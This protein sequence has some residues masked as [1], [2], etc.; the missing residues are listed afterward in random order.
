MYKKLINLSCLVLLLGLA[1]K[2]SAQLLVHYKLDETSGTVAADMSGKGNDG[3]IDGA[4]NWAPGWID[5]ALQF[6]GS[7]S[8]T[9]PA[10]NMGLRS[11]TGSVAF[12]MNMAELMGG[13][14][15]IWW[16]GDNT[17]G[18]GMGPENEMHVHIETAVADVW[19]GGE[20][21]FRV[22]HGPLVHLHS[23]PE[24]GDA[25]VP[26]NPPVN[27]V[28]VNDGQWHHVVCTWGDADGNVNLYLDGSLLQQAAYTTPSYPL[29][30]IYLG[31]M[32]DGGR[33]YT[34][35][36]DDVQIY[37]GALTEDEIQMVMAGSEVLSLPAALPEPANQATDVPLDTVLS[38][39]AGDR[40]DKHNV[41]FGTSLED[42]ENADTTNPR[43]V[44][45]AEN[46]DAS[47]YAP[48]ELLEFDQTYYWRVDEVNAP[49]EAGIIK[50]DIWSFT[51]VNFVVVDDFE[52]YTDSSPDIV[53]ET[54]LD[55][56]EIEE[57]GSN[58]GY[59]DPPTMEQDI[60]HG[61]SKSMPFFYDNNMRYSQAE[62]S[63]TGSTT[64]WTAND[65]V[66]VSLWFRGNRRY[67]GSFVEEPAGTFTLTGSGADI[68]AAADEFHFAFKEVTGAS[69]I[70]AKVESLDNTDPFAKAGV[71]IRDTL[72]ADS[73]YAGVFIT[74]ENGVRFQ[75]RN[76]VAATT[77]RSFAEGITAPQWVKLERTTG[78]LIRSYYSADG[79]TWTRFNLIQVAMEMPVYVGLAVTSHNAELA[80]QAA[81]SNV[82][83]PN[84]TVAAEWTDQ[85]VGMLSNH[86]EPMYLALNGKAVYHDDP[87]AVLIDTWTQ[88]T[89]PLQAFATQG[90]DLTNVETLA[91]GFGDK[92]N[93]RP[94]G[95][96]TVYFDDIRLYR[97]QAVEGPVSVPIE[98]SSFE[99][100]GTD[101]QT[102][103]DNVAGWSTDGPCADSGVETGYTPTDGD[104]TAYLMSGDPSVWQLTDHI[105]AEGQTIEL[106]ID[107]R[108][109][110]AATSMLMVIYYDDN[111]TRVPV[112]TIDVVLSD[113]M[114]EFNLSFSAGDVPESVGRNVGI[115]FS[116]S[117]SGDTWVGLD[118][119]RLE[120]SAK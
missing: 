27:P 65:V 37:G 86:A 5:G 46:Q 74:P 54:W 58:I 59:A 102:G 82:S 61:G 70:I 22:L 120:A 94:G 32:A 11:D 92:D 4:A 10:G 3:V 100:P 30:N 98:N 1:G 57:N 63:L 29:T 90:I 85:D 62:R 117:S 9:L 8:V 50:G 19:Q 34:G 21:C 111:E 45:V 36:L 103:F 75:Y 76:A 81:F 84:T 108:I 79:S 67:V 112:A 44:L 116:N 78:G 49:P 2:T 24:K 119:V 16:G 31:Q 28:L 66:A 77:E 35:L 106:K 109:T 15:T 56:W 48:T 25:S 93:L 53:Y 97:P 51:T 26:G 20:L 114:Q 113:S 71:M 110:W 39:L 104:W 23:D 33:T 12:W 43:G 115:E 101:K 118:N 60:I 40:A 68:W 107:A 87:N 88:W 42:V 96:G 38:W 7:L 91:V 83:F 6:D 72:D 17:T 64:D 55:G 73:R 18:G 80:C 105:I 99:L 14:N 41:Y 95:S 47:T 89:A 13:I 52:S 69:A